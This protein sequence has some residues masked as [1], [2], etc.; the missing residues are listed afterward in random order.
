M[1]VRAEQNGCRMTEHIVP[2]CPAGHIDMPFVIEV[3]GVY[4]GGLIWE[5]PVC[6]AKWPRFNEGRLHR[7]ALK[8]IEEWKNENADV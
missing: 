2:A 3:R 6:H 8:V 5:C 4:D 7:A 1:L